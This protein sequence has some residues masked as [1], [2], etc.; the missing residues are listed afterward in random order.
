MGL[1]LAEKVSGFIYQVMNTQFQITTE[2]WNR[3]VGY[4]LRFKML[5]YRTVCSA[6]NQRNPIATREESVEV[7][8]VDLVIIRNDF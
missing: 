2:S 1:V 7:T 4:V 3:E 6:N 5:D 8:R